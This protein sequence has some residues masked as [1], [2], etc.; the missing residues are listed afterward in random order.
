MY[1]H[2][3]RQPAGGGRAVAASNSGPDAQLIGAASA[4]SEP[5]SLWYPSPA[6]V[7][8]EALPVRNGRLGAM[9]F[10][11]ADLNL[12]PARLRFVKPEEG[13]TSRRKNGYAVD[14][15]IGADGVA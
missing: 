14:C 12:F 11:E 3:A 5:L 8:T 13:I 4:P 9:V 7:W 6:K 15:R 2:P 1:D 10:G